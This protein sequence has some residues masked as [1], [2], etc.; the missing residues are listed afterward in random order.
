MYSQKN[1][2]ILKSASLVANC[3][4]VVGLCLLS[5]CSAKKNVQVVEETQYIEARVPEEPEGVARYCWEEPIA[6]YQEQGPGVDADGH[7]YHPSYTAVRKARQGR[8]RPCQ[9]ITS[10]RERRSK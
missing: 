10:E 3:C 4:L 6:V 9:E 7:W 8:W 2:Q 1:S 5:S